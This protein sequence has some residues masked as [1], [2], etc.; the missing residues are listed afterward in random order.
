MKK[1]ILTSLLIL[2]LCLCACGNDTTAEPTVTPENTANSGVMVKETP[3]A[4][5]NEGETATAEPTATP[6]PTPE[7]T[8]A[9]REEDDLTDNLVPEKDA[10]FEGITAYEETAWEN[11]WSGSYK[12]VEGYAGQGLE[13]TPQVGMNYCSASYNICPLITEAG[14]YE[15]SFRI[16]YVGNVKAM[17]N[18]PAGVLIRGGKNYSNS[19]ILEQPSGNAYVRF[20]YNVEG[21]LGDWQKITFLFTCEEEDISADAIWRVCLEQIDSNVTSFVIDNFCVRMA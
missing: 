21:D 3:V 19:F 1:I 15:V 5:N 12:V 17:P 18:K 7:P 8:P 13:F 20:N 10:T 6:E 2:A 16:K 9:P 11:V 14:E 4:D